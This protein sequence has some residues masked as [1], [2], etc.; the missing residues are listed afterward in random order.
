MGVTSETLRGD[1]D[2][3]VA[4]GESGFVGGVHLRAECDDSAPDFT[5]R[6]RP[7]ATAR[8]QPA[9][10]QL[11]A[12]AGRLG[13]HAGIGVRALELRLV[14]QQL[15]AAIG[16]YSDALSR[17]E[18]GQRRVQP[19]LSRPQALHRDYQVAGVDAR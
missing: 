1:G 9:L 2:V 15:V 18:F 6:L 7:S 10:E 12:R 8:L 17:A 5:P 14:D 16:V 19:R 3:G 13:E 11:S 4:D